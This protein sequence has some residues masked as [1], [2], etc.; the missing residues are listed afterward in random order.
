MVCQW[1]MSEL[2]PISFGSNSEVFLGRDLVRERDFSEETA[3]AVDKAIHAILDEAY[4]EARD[5]MTKHKDI[6][7]AIS[8]ALVER[9]TLEGDELDKIIRKHGG[10]DLLPR[11]DREPPAG[12][13]P[14]RA[15]V[16]EQPRDEE[17]PD[18][19]GLQPGP[20]T[21]VPHPA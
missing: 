17:E 13:R 10:Q 2:G 11:K 4:S 6:L 18:S 15:V 12:P 8:E 16:A 21:P 9:E 7:L 1:G 14:S 20:E 3:S 19:G 5:L